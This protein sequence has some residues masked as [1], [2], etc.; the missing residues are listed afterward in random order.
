MGD[1]MM[2][3][4]SIDERVAIPCRFARSHRVFTNKRQ[5]HAIPQG[6]VV[7]SAVINGTTYE[8]PLDAASFDGETFYLRRDLAERDGHV[9]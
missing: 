1:V 9:K 7:W 5:R 4:E 2:T 3:A 6:S 8:Y